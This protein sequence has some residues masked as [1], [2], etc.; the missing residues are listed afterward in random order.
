MRK[1][2]RDPDGGVRD[3]QLRYGKRGVLLAV[4]GSWRSLS[5]LDLPFAVL[6]LVCEVASYVCLWQLD[7]IA[8]RTKGWF[9]VATAQLT[10]NLAGRIFP[11]GGA[12][13]A[14]LSASMLHGAGADTGDAVA[15]F[16]AS[17]ALQLGT[18]AAL[19]VLA[20]PAI[21][22]GAPVNHSLATAAY[23]GA[24]LFVLLLVAGTALMRSTVRGAS[25]F[26]LEASGAVMPIAVAFE[27]GKDGVRDLI[28]RR[29]LVIEDDDRQVRLRCLQIAC[30][31]VQR[32]IGQKKIDLRPA[33]GLQRLERV[34]GCQ[35]V[36]APVAESR[37]DHLE[38]GGVIMHHHDRRRP[39]SAHGRGKRS[40]LASAHGRDR[41]TA[42]SV[43]AAGRGV[44]SA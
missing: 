29:R 36:S 8:L 24:A 7:R 21:L 18:T 9:P 6:V 33:N 17:T 3:D 31:V 20:L 34:E 41:S 19:P 2:V 16:G 27:S 5:H 39:A 28:E 22:G 4:F 35:H 13:A 15:A 40:R 43:Y 42:T 11:G 10:G 25:R 37:L 14:A 32:S 44:E 1:F 30:H 23:L 26:A 12:T 38:H